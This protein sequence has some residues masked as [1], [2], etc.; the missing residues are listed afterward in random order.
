MVHAMVSP[1]VRSQLRVHEALENGRWAND[2]GPDMDAPT[3]MEFMVLWQRV[4]NIQIHVGTPDVTKWAWEPGG[5]YTARSAYAALFMGRQLPPTA[6]FTWKFRAPLQCRFFVW[7]A[8]KNR[9]W[10][11]DRLARRGL[12]HQDTCPLCNQEDET[13]SHI[14][15]QCVF[16]RAF[17]LQ[18]CTALDKPDWTP[19]RTSTL[20]VWILGKCI[21]GMH[22]KDLRA[23]LTLGF[24]ELWKHRNDIVFDGESPSLQRL[25]GRIL[26]EGRAWRTAGLLRTPG[27]DPLT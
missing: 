18:L 16:S 27:L 5:A 2:V 19:T 6:D 1:R 23:L 11:S 12:Q 17:W 3:L 21:Q 13:M 25:L 8:M 14:M 22:D 10:I 20:P 9:C 7:L 15:L 4:G 24:W 26:V